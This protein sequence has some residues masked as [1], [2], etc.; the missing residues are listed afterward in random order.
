[1]TSVWSR[2]R[3]TGDTSETEHRLDVESGLHLTTTDSECC[4]SKT[5]EKWLTC[6]N[7]QYT[8]AIDLKKTTPNL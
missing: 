2:D 4:A 7:A 3:D 8:M 1:M 5:T 6:L